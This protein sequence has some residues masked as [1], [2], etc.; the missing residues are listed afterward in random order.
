MRLGVSSPDVIVVGAGFAG[1]SAACLLA[2][3]GARVLVLEARPQLGG[4]ATA[5]VDRE[6]G[7][8]VD[9]GQHVLFGCYRATFEFLR[10]IG[11]EHNVAHQSTLEI[12]CYDAAGLRSVLRCPPVPAPLHLLAGVLS[13]KPIPWLDRL[14][15]LR[16][17]GSLR[18]ARRELRNGR[19][20][21]DS[22]ESVRGWLTRHGQRK[23]L[24]QWLWEPL[25]VAALNQSIDHA[26]AA[27]FV[28]VLAEMFSSDRSDASL[29][30]PLK[31]LDETYASPARD[32]I[33]RH[34]GEVRTS[35]LA[36]VHVGDDGA[37]HVD[38]GA[39]G[40]AVPKV[41]AAVA[42]HSLGNLFSGAVGALEGIVSQTRQMES[43]PIV[44][45]NLWYDR[46]IMTEPFAGLPGRTMQWVFDKRLTFG[47][48]AS[49][50]SLVSSGAS[51]IAARS[52]QD[53]ISLARDEIRRSLPAAREANVLRATVIREKRA[54]FSLAPGQPRRPGPRTGVPGLF[55]AGD[56]TDTGLP[57]TIE[58]AVVSGHTAARAI[59]G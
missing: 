45:V 34:G 28:R 36:R 23:L 7:E 2:E 32:F 49:H 54:T 57:A 40:W 20:L 46:T 12:P 52:N 56:W 37:H 55:L 17:V 53:L 15:V 13:W 38:A 43:M 27:P 35:T 3:Q 39:E 51:A 59:L 10:R 24:M 9:N 6:T 26:S 33:L 42:W 58:G 5:F 1:L 14:A 4:R 48:R 19:P 11:A 30:L 44:T 8:R 16:L 29:V 21:V 18:A 50:L 41:V 22:G 31:P 47:E 25:A